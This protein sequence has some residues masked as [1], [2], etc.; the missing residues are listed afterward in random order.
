[1]KKARSAPS[2]PKQFRRWAFRARYLRPFCAKTRIRQSNSAIKCWNTSKEKPTWRASALSPTFR[3][4]SEIR[5]ATGGMRRGWASP[6]LVRRIFE[7]ASS[8]YPD[9][10]IGVHLHSAPGEAAAKV[11]AAYDAGCRRF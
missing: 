9:P 3:W 11:L 5:T 7:S 1:M 8:E 4:H 6:D 10:E 2:P